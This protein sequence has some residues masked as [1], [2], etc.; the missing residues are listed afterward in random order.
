MIF[1]RE[2]AALHAPHRDLDSDEDLDGLDEE[3]D[4]LRMIEQFLP[5]GYH[6]VYRPTHQDLGEDRIRAHQLLRG[7]LSSKRV[8]SRSAISALESVEISLLPDSERSK[9]DTNLV[10]GRLAK[11]PCDEGRKR[12]DLVCVSSMRHLLQ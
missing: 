4:P 8:A 9:Q 5:G 10:L 11:L 1:H 12:A 2:R 6:D 3:A 7:Q